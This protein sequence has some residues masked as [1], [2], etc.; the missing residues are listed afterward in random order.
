MPDGYLRRSVLRNIAK[1]IGDDDLPDDQVIGATFHD[2]TPST[3]SP[4]LNHTAVIELSA[5]FGAFIKGVRPAEPEEGKRVNRHRWRMLQEG[6][7]RMTATHFCDE[8]AYRIDLVR[9][10]TFTELHNG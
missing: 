4:I 5:K 2:T 8:L 7:E 9:Q 10:T 6:S 1:R 3:F